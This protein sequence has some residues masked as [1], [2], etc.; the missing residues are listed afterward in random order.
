MPESPRAERRRS[1]TRSALL[2]LSAVRL[3]PL[4]LR[5]ERDLGKSGRLDPAHHAH[6]RAIVDALVAPDEDLLVIAVLGYGLELRGDI[7][8]LDLR[9]L[10]ED[11]AGPVDAERDRILVGLQ[12]LALGLRQFD[13][14]A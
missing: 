4:R 6:H 2:L 7:I 11:L 5:H 8:E 10:D 14:H 1:P 13:R 12:L 9:F 3:R